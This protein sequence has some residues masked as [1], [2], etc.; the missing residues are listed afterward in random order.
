MLAVAVTGVPSW[1]VPVP[2]VYSMFAD[3]RCVS[4]LLCGNGEPARRSE[5]RRRGDA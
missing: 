2:F 3:N 4:R 1:L 5:V